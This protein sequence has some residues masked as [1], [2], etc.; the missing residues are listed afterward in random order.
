M[1]PG[2]EYWVTCACGNEKLSTLV[3]RF[4]VDA[5]VVNVEGIE[6]KLAEKMQLRYRT[7]FKRGALCCRT[8]GASCD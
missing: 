3:S 8:P 6:D 5:H 1:M 2:R 4:M 7:G